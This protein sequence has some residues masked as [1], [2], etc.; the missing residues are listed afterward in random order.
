MLGTHLMHAPLRE[1]F[2]LF[3]NQ[4]YCWISKLLAGKSLTVA[5]CQNFT[6]LYISVEHS[7]QPKRIWYISV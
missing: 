4:S 2:F 3:L 1:T 6:N 5:T 7:K